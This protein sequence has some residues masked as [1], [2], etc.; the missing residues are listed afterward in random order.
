M[1]PMSVHIFH[2]TRNR[3]LFHVAAVVIH[4][5][6]N[7][8]LEPRAPERRGRTIFNRCPLPACAGGSISAFGT[9]PT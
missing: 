3:L 9:G 8:I 5:H 7:R 1:P 4:Q 6:A 2:A